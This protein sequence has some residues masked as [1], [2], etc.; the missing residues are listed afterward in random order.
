VRRDLAQFLRPNPKDLL[1]RP[2]IGAVLIGIPLQ[3]FAEN[4]IWIAR[5]AG[6]GMTFVQL[7]FA[8]LVYWIRGWSLSGYALAEILI[9]AWAFDAA[10]TKAKDT[11]LPHLVLTPP[12]RIDVIVQLAVG[13]YLAVDGIDNAR[14]A[15]REARVD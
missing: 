7:G 3:H 2:G 11:P 4:F 6:P 12:E 14:R 1:L 15:F 9:A 8:A 13:I 10:L 5:H